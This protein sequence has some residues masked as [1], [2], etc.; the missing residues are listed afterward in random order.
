M[1]KDIEAVKSNRE[2]YTMLPEK[3]EVSQVIA[4]LIINLGNSKEE[5]SYF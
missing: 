3:D 1:V 4:E 2:Q 5:A